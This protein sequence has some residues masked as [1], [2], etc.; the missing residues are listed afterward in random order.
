VAVNIDDHL[1]HTFTFWLRRI[2]K[3]QGLIDDPIEH[4]PENT[5]E[6][7]KQVVIQDIN[8]GFIEN[9]LHVSTF[10]ELEDKVTVAFDLSKKEDRLIEKFIR[11]EPMIRAVQLNEI[12]FEDKSEKHTEDDMSMVSETMAKI[13]SDQHLYDKAIT[14]Y[15]K[16]SLKFPEKKLYFATQIE[17]LRQLGQV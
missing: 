14:V 13:Y 7:I 8:K 6:S 1:P 12:S 15:E 2:R 10:N 3:A 17:K 5:N 4:L 11:E 16:L 9:A